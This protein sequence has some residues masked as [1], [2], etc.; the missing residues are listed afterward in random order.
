[1][2]IKTNRSRDECLS[3]LEKMAMWKFPQSRQNTERNR[4]LNNLQISQQKV[5]I[6]WKF[7]ADVWSVSS[8]LKI[9]EK[10][11]KIFIGEWRSAMT[12]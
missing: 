1:L 10:P 8:E 2:I 5:E 3:I 11:W 9:F 6:Q 12:T 4:P 7:G